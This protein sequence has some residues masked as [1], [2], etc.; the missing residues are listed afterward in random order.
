MIDVKIKCK[1]LDDE[2]EQY[3]SK[4][5]KLKTHLSMVKQE[6]SI[7]ESLLAQRQKEIDAKKHEICLIERETGQLKLF[8][9]NIAKQRKEIANRTDH[10]E[11]KMLIDDQLIESYLSEC[12]NN[13]KVRERLQY[14]QKK[15]DSKLAV[16]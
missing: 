9:S 16:S 2:I 14:I 15:D 11:S 7:T 1:V 10:F 8:L 13:V 5:D 4:N 3:R 12:E 6:Q